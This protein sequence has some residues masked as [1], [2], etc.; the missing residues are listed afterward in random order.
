MQPAVAAAIVRKRAA[1]ATTVGTGAVLFGC[2]SIGNSINSNSNLASHSGVSRAAAQL[3]AN[4]NCSSSAT[5]VRAVINAAARAARNIGVVWDHLRTMRP[6]VTVAAMVCGAAAVGWSAV[7]WRRWARA[8][9]AH[10][11]ALTALDSFLVEASV[12]DNSVTSPPFLPRICSRSRMGCIVP[13]SKVG[14]SNPA[15][16]SRCGSL[17]LCSSA[18]T[19]SSND[20]IAFKG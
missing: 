16:T 10:L 3:L 5:P 12:S 13:H 6:A 11:D 19:R 1:I 4:P 2:I 18:D 14:R 9:R 7:L 17:L 15:A 20:V 8:D